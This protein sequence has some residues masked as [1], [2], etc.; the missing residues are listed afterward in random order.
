MVRIFCLGAPRIALSHESAALALT[1]KAIALFVYLVVTA[2]K[3]KPPPS[4]DHLADLLWSETNNQQARTNLR[5]LLPEVRRQLGDYLIITPQTIAW[6][7]QAPYW[8]D[9]EQLR[10]TLTARPETITTL[11]LQANLD[12][13]QGEFL[14][15]FMVRNVP[16]F[17][18]WVVRQREEVHALVVQGGYTLAERYWQQ[19]DY[20]AGLTA[21]QRLLQ[22]EPWHEAGHRLQMQ[23]LA[24]TGQKV[25]ALSQYDRC[26]TILAKELGVEPEATT[27]ALYEQLRTGAFD[28]VT[29]DRV[30]SD[31]ATGDRVT[32]NHPVTLSPPENPL[33]AVT[34]SPSPL[35]FPSSSL[36]HNL[37]SNLTPFFGRDAEIAQISALLTDERYRLVTLVGEGGSGKTRL[38]LAA[39]QAI[40]AFGVWILPGQALDYPGRIQTP[41]F[42]DGVWFVALHPIPTTGNLADQLAVAV[43]QA[44]GLS[45]SGR[46]PLFTQ[47]LTH[48]HKKALLLIFDNAE[49]LL[50]DL[51][52]LLVQILQA[53][54]AVTALVTSRHLLGL[55]AEF[56]WRVAGLAV[57]PNDNLPPATLLTYSSIALFV[58]RARRR[59][60]TFD[61]TVANQAAL[62]GIC[63]LVDGLPLAIELAAALTQAYSSTELYTHLQQDYTILTTRLRDLPARHR[64]IQA[65]LDY[66]WRFL[67]PAEADALAA[68]SIFA[69]SFSR[70]AALAVAGA[71]PTVLSNLVDQSLLQVHEG[72]FIMHE[73]IRHYAAAQLAQRPSAQHA[74]Q[75]R[76]AAYYMALLQSLEGALLVTVAAQETAQHDLDN[77]R[78][79]WLWS[80]DQADL[81]L[82]AMGAA[83]LQTVYRLAGLYREAIQ[84]LHTALQNVRRVIDAPPRAADQGDLA[85]RQLFGCL[86]CYSALFYRRFGA[87]EQGEEAA[88]EALALGQAQNDPALQG[89]AY[90]ELARL[91]QVRS[92]FLAMYQWAELGCTQAQQSQSPQLV[93]ECLNDLGIAVSSCQHPQTAIPH[94]H[95]ALTQ[96]P[97]G[98][99]RYLEARLRANL[100]FF[101]LSCHEYQP[102][103]H[104]L[105]QAFTLQQQIQDR[106]GSMITQ[107]FLGD[108]WLALGAYPL[109]QQAYEQGLSR[110]QSIPDPYWKSWLHASY[111]RLQY[112]CGD[113]AAAHAAGMVARQ[114]AQEG[115]SH[116]Q[117]QWILIN[118]GQ[119]LMG[120]GD[121]T[122]ARACY[123][124]A[125]ALH[126][127]TSWVY[128]TADAHAGLAAL[129]LAQQEIIAAIG[130]AEAALAFLAERG[131]A[132]ANEPF[133]LY[134]TSFCIFTAA[135][136]PRAATVLQTAYQQLQTIADQIEDE[137]LR[138][139][140]CEGVVINRQLIAAAQAAAAP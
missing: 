119:A 47:V 1:P 86:L 43:A 16:V 30:T 93:A 66:S 52:D 120:V 80:A 15:G 45:F 88:Q 9:V 129:L 19:A 82:L 32:M 26:R 14:A 8:L 91:A 56:V 12:L 31:K 18:E 5:Y 51:A 38:A 116:I 104:N 102:A 20:Q 94:F 139:S 22:W 4:R 138:H 76:H 106:E 73:L 89:L 92:D 13:Y 70:A 17:E 72:R 63:R 83:S 81:S 98:V 124:Q 127:K 53:G 107:I 134:W 136:D 29:S 60:H 103:Y 62:V 87:V 99:N 49:H 130:Q 65:M 117:E 108:L 71:A 11:A 112:L 36:P 67:A 27:T 122:A 109:A 61:L 101:H 126:D 34:S 137:P 2:A 24:A 64:S 96:L 74:A 68:C 111:A 44:V 97:T 21:T 131:L 54:P 28:R 40:L 39:A 57:P 121:L 114:I 37:P 84:L 118:L 128:R 55:H 132:A 105:T 58:E 140:F 42:L 100:G 78:A 123:E 59:N 115:K 125:I 23:L 46:Q 79:A 25:A 69:G 135:S 110:M 90:H 77:L 95:A 10:T 6:Q 7:R 48:L 113:P 41:K 75:A 33:G 35:V 133:G 3:G 85:A 50:P